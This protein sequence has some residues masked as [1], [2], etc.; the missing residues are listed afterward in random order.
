MSEAYEVLSDDEKRKLYDEGGKE[1]VEHGHAGGGGG[2]D[3]FDILR[4]NSRHD[5]LSVWVV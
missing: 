5:F 2:V 3:I 1:A 4:G